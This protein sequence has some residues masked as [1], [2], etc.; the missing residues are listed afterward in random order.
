[1]ATTF[2]SQGSLAHLGTV[3]VA[4]AIVAVAAQ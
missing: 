4:L 1:L 2:A 3:A